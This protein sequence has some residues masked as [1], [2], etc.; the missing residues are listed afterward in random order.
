[1]IFDF[2]PLLDHL[3]PWL[4]VLF[5]FTGIFILSPLLGSATVPRLVK[6]ILAVSLS[7]CV[8]PTL[9]APH[10]GSAAWIG[11]II[12]QGLSLWTMIP[13]VAVELLIG[14]TVGYAA[15][16]PL[17]GLQLGGRMIDQ[18]MGLGLG[19]VFNPELESQSGVVGEFLF[20]LAL[21]I[22]AI[23]GG[24]ERMFAVLVESFHHIPLGGFDG[25][26]GLVHLVIGLLT[27]AFELAFRIAAPLLCLLFLQALALGFIMRTVPQMNILSVG[28]PVRILV[29]AGFLAIFV[30]IAGREFVEVLEEVFGMLSLFLNK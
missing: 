17:V 1:M 4:M 19:G 27:I 15:S 25:F 29:G 3:P 14:F 6:A 24:H 8:Y 9:L 10:L 5:R 23:L 20:I 30:Q 11:A 7:L 21:A 28:F 22:F 16:L 2:G 26:G 18:Q 12:D 13:V